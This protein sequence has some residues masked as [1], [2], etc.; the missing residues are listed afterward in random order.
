DF[1]QS[2]ACNQ[3]QFRKFFHAMLDRGVY[4]APSAFEAGFVSAAHS[5]ED[6]QQTLDAAEEAFAEVV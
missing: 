2:M 3:E 1:T 4:L 5:D 6:L